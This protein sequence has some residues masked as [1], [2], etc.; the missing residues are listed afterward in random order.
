ML[1]MLSNV[2]NPTPLVRL[3]RVVPFKH[4]AVYAKLESNQSTKAFIQQITAIRTA[5]GGSPDLSP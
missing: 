4:A 5:V 3:H 2:D 1:E